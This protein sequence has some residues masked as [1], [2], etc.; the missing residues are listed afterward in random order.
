MMYCLDTK[1]NMFDE[2]LWHYQ[3][4]VLI[5]VEGLSPQGGGPMA[6]KAE[7]CVWLTYPKIGLSTEDKPVIAYNMLKMKQMVFWVLL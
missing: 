2:L 4:V 5:F 3:V 1:S 6:T 7:E